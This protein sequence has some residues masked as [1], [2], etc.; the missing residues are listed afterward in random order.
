MVEQV[1]AVL[2][3][4]TREADPDVSVGVDNVIRG[5]VIPPLLKESRASVRRPLLRRMRRS[6]SLSL[7]GN[8]GDETTASATESDLLMDC[9][10]SVASA[11]SRAFSAAIG[12]GAVATTSSALLGVAPPPL[13]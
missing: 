10:A 7:S 8:I 12:T 3:E 2:C 9:L 13:R 4:S 1:G 6:W 11:T 5:L